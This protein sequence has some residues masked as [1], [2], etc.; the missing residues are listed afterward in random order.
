MH[1]NYAWHSL[2]A[3]RDRADVYMRG[4]SLQQYVY[5]FTYELP[6]AVDDKQTHGDADQGIGQHPA[7]TPDH[8]TG[9][10]R[11]N[12]T[13]RVSYHVEERPAH[14][15]IVLGCSVKN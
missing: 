4:R 2:H 14:I 7:P 15:E 5:R 9:D 11:S 6:R 8:D 1:I 10:N 12:R 13:Q 3:F